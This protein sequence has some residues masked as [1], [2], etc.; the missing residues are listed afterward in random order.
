MTATDAA[1]NIMLDRLRA[2]SLLSLPNGS[3]PGQSVY[4]V[5]GEVHLGSSDT[6]GTFPGNVTYP[7]IAIVVISSENVLTQGTGQVVMTNGLIM[8]KVV[9]TGGNLA[10]ERRIAE[11]VRTVL[12]AIKRATWTR[13]PGE[14]VYYVSEIVWVRYMGQPNE[15]IG[16]RVFRFYNLMYRTTGNERSGG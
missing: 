7:A 10:V 3:G 16:N 6:T 14:P 2:D 9:A 11:R 8:V 4:G 5:R 15:E 1:T 12:G 13:G